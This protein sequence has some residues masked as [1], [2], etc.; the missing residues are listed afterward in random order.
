MINETATEVDPVRASVK[1]GLQDAIADPETWLKLRD[2]FATYARSEAGGWV[3]GAIGA[4]FKKVA[5]G[6]VIIG[7][8]YYVGGFPAVAAWFKGNAANH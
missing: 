3:L 5:L 7:A 6:V 4:I 1:A 8:L 2:A